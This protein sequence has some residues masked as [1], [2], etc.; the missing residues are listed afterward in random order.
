MP[1]TTHNVYGIPRPPFSHRS[2]TAVAIWSSPDKTMHL[3]DIYKFYRDQL[4]FYGQ[5]SNSW[6]Y[7][8]DKLLNTNKCFMRVLKV[9]AMNLP[10]EYWTLHPTVLQDPIFTD[11]T[12]L[13]KRNPFRIVDCDADRYVKFGKI[14][15]YHLTTINPCQ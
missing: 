3:T 13:W 1:R 4:L 9:G 15:C 11:Q 8:V 2:L 10:S 12:L 5:N 6:R 7:S 14:S